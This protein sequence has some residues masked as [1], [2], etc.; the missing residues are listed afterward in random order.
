MDG[1]EK[2]LNGFEPVKPIEIKRDDGR[3]RSRAGRERLNL[4]AIAERV[5]GMDALLVDLLAPGAQQSWLVIAMDE[6]RRRGRQDDD[7]GVLFRQP[8]H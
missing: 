8:E 5:H 3:E 7:A 4:L 6:D 1:G 2:S